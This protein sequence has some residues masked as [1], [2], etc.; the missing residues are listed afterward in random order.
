PQGQVP[1][2]SGSFAEQTV[3]LYGPY[4]Q[5]V[6]RR[7]LHRVL[8]EPICVQVANHRERLF[9]ASESRQDNGWD[10]LSSPAQRPHQVES[11]QPRHHQV[12]NDN[13]GRPRIELL[14]SLLSIA[15]GCNVESLSG[16]STG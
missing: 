7:E 12:R 14:K 16:E 3:V 6:Q 15:G 11:V 4:Q 2:Q 8:Q 10:Y 9:Y 5:R 13:F 1:L